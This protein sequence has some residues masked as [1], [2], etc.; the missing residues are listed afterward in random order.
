MSSPDTMRPKSLKETQREGNENIPAVEGLVFKDNALPLN[1]AQYHVYQRA[2]NI[3]R[4]IQDLLHPVVLT[5]AKDDTAAM[6]MKAVR[7]SV[8]GSFVERQFSFEGRH[9][10]F[11]CW[12]GTGTG[13]AFRYTQKHAQTRNA[14]VVML[15]NPVARETPYPV[16][17]ANIPGQTMVR[18]ACGSYFQNLKE[19]VDQFEKLRALTGGALRTPPVLATYV[20][21][22]E[23]AAQQ[24]LPLPS[25]ENPFV[26][27]SP[28]QYAGRIGTD[29]EFEP[30]HGLG[31]QSHFLGENIRAIEN[32]F[33]V[34]D[35]E[36]SLKIADIGEKEKQLR[37]I[38]DASKAILE[39]KFGLPMNHAGYLEK[40][41]E[42]LA[43]QT[44]VLLEYGITHGSMYD[45]KQD[46]TLAAE[47][48][49]LDAAYHLDNDYIARVGI[50]KHPWVKSLPLGDQEKTL[51]DSEEGLRFQQILRIAAHLQP[52]LRAVRELEPDTSMTDAELANNFV[53]QLTSSP[54]WIKTN[55]Q[56]VSFLAKEETR[57]AKYRYFSHEGLLREGTEG[58]TEQNFSGQELYLQAVIEAMKNSSI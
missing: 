41:S 12:K 44:A 24:G 5:D 39:R 18:F 21:S 30:G 56:F 35:I 53:R 40:F 22:R 49:D 32:P 29:F 34:D 1:P 48:A 20:F 25:D 9:Y 42:L 37:T 28:K 52:I 16:F 8:R 23:F 31:Y 57:E 33:R 11:L 38:L 27:E 43:E 4:D 54:R 6:K 7:S 17:K 15:N 26:G 45:H 58:T 19:E 3:P 36:Q 2:E 13:A 10:D 14:S 51:W 47:I 46:I 50:A 55:D